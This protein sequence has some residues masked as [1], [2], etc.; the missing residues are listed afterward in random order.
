MSGQPRMRL[1]THAYRRFGSRRKRGRAVM[2]FISPSSAC[3]RRSRC[4]VPGFCCSGNRNRGQSKPRGGRTAIIG[5]AWPAGAQNVRL[6]AAGRSPAS[7]AQSD[8]QAIFRGT[9][10]AVPVPVGGGGSST[11]RGWRWPPLL[12]PASSIV[13]LPGPGP[14]SPPASGVPGRGGAA[15]AWARSCCPPASRC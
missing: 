1:R 5:C 4:F 8:H 7:T 9:G 12:R 10:R 11:R 3:G 14:G 6:R 13:W 15:P 2:S